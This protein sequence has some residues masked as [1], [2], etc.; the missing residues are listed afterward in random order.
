MFI[1]WFFLNVMA[2]SPFSN[3]RAISS[4]RKLESNKILVVYFSC[5]GN[6][7][8]VATNINSIVGGDLVEIV[9]SVPYTSEDLDYGNSES[10]TSKERNDPT[11][12]PEIKNDINNFNEYTTI[13]LGYPL[14][15]AKAPNIIRTFMKK[16]DFSDKNIITFSTSSSSSDGSKSFLP[17]LAPTA[18]WNE[19]FKRFSSSAQES[20]VKTW[21]DTLDLDKDEE[22]ST[23]DKVVDEESS[24]VDQKTDEGT[25]NKPSKK[26]VVYFSCTGNTK[27]VATN[28]NSIVG[29][30]LVEIV[31]SVPYTSEDLDY[32]NSESRTS[33]ERNDPT[34][35]PEIKNDINNF[36]EYTTILLGYPLWWAKAPNII[37]T[38]MKKY[39]F[40]D[41]NII[42]FS[43][44]SSSSDGS[45]SFLPSLAPTAK[46]NEDFKRF[47]SSA[48][49]SEVKTW[50]DTL[51]LDKDE[52]TSTTES[53]GS[54]TPG[55]DGHG[56][57]NDHKIVVAYFSAT[58]NTKRIAQ[59]I[60]NTLKYGRI[61]EIEPVIPYT[62]SDLNYNDKDSRV[63]KEHNDPNFRPEFKDISDINRAETIL[64]GY[65]IWW[66]EAPH[67]VY[68]FIEKFNLKDKTVIP[69]CTSASSKM[70]NSGSN[71]AAKAKNA[72]WLEGQRFSS[73]ASSNT[74]ED[75]VDS[76]LEVNS[77]NEIKFI[78][79]NHSKKGLSKGAIA[80]IVVGCVVVV[81]VIIAVVIVVVKRKKAKVLSKEDSVSDNP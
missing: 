58:G 53:T 22:S 27:R 41:K 60:H 1:S 35:L 59:S 32:G 25:V 37:R 39:D 14:W 81:A 55:S 76:L 49:E 77:E 11:I 6:T 44:S 80:G 4:N 23:E 12:L 72:N 56:N 42:T 26:L 3:E 50:I 10:R 24:T 13:L 54:T 45:K 52:E 51:D 17:S 64:V 79:G 57:K 62:S 78:N 18:K 65:P 75:W 9:P 74:V 48:Q 31:P 5:T 40:S 38:F 16:Y 46:W 20:E 71:L 43:T 19:D 70:G 29:G 8:R 2:N 67:I 66:G 73:S 36:N 15:W 63:S 21:I 61:V 47:S 33:K 68:S 30:D 7:K 28:I 69:F 34:I